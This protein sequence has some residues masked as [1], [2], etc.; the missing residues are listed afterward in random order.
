MAFIIIFIALVIIGIFINIIIKYKEIETKEKLLHDEKTKI[1][2]LSIFTDIKKENYELYK[3]IILTFK[4]LI[5][6]SY[7]DLLCE[8]K[9]ET[10]LEILKIILQSKININGTNLNGLTYLMVACKFNNINAVKELL[11]NGANPHIATIHNG[12]YKTVFNYT[13][14]KNILYEL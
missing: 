9:S 10:D 3:K 12:I 13:L 7:V 4:N 6:R 1:C 14:N 11:Q 2:L 8:S 5:T